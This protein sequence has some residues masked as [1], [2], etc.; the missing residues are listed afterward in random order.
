MSNTLIER[1]PLLIATEINS[2]KDQ[3]RKILLYSAIEI[4]RRLTEAKS[5]VEHG[6]W[7]KWLEDS[8][9]YSQRTADNLMR[10]FAEYGAGLPSADDRANSQTFANLSYSQAV[11]LL[12]IPEDER[13]KFITENEIESMSVR[14]L[15]KAVKERNQ[16]LEEK[17][18][19]QKD[20]NAKNSNLN[21]VTNERDNLRKEAG[22][23]RTS[24]SNEQV[25]VK[26]LRQEL[27]AAQ[28][29]SSAE[30]VAALEKDLAAAQTRV[31]ANK[32][33]VHF[34]NLVKGADELLKGLAEIS[35]TDPETHENY[36]TAVSE[37]I[38][39]IAQKL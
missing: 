16:A 36:K 15:S 10:I 26:K 39:S 13:L 18:T 4:G 2:I 37:L 1:T 6:E 8:V 34:D 5:L 33:A 21:L 12:G 11:I 9:N 19:L 38:A 20:L 14:E 22:K 32:V 28:K 17:E 25:I 7:G 30:R 29:S 3:A 23:L 31:S 35:Q 27:A 24:Y